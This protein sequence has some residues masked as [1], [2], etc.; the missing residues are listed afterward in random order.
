MTAVNELSIRWGRNEW[1]FTVR[2]AAITRLRISVNPDGRISVAAP[3]HASDEAIRERV[4]RRGDWIARQLDRVEQWRPRT[5]PR[6]YVTGE[7]HWYQGRQ[8]RLRVLNGSPAGVEL[9]GDRLTV[10]AGENVERDAIRDLVQTWYRRQARDL[11]RR[12]F[13]RQTALL[14]R[15]RI[16]TPRLIVRALSSRWGSLTAA[17]SLVLNSDL[18]RA[19]PRLVDYVIAHEMAHAIYPDHGSAWRQLLGRMMPDWQSRKRDL[20]RQLL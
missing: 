18:V 7:T 2:R 14:E 16:G 5:P 4:Q 11:L 1:T 9:L 17:G 15:Y 3:P 8:L 19:S 13:E 6:Q 12:R 10:H 20:E